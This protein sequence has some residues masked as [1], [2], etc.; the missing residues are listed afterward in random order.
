MILNLIRAEFLKY[1]RFYLIKILFVL[2]LV[3]AGFLF[4]S[5][6]PN[7]KDQGILIMIYMLNGYLLVT[8]YLSDYLLKYD[9]DK[10][11]I[12]LSKNIR[13]KYIIRKII[14][15]TYFAFIG[16]I[17]LYLFMT[18]ALNKIDPTLFN[19]SSILQLLLINFLLLIPFIIFISVI[20][21]FTNIFLSTT[22][23]LILLFF[24]PFINFMLENYINSKWDKANNIILKIYN[25]S[26][27]ANTYGPTNLWTSQFVD[28]QNIKSND[29]FNSKTKEIINKDCTNQLNEKI[30][31]LIKEWKKLE[32]EWAMKLYPEFIESNKKELKETKK[33]WDKIINKCIDSKTSELVYLYNWFD[34]KKYFISNKN[35]TFFY[36]WLIYNL[37]FL[38]LWAYLM[39]R[40]EKN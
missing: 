32:I 12:L 22:I 36:L 11:P 1:K 9:S 5:V 14:V 21:S 18:I 4:Y 13:Y 3:L 31:E 6:I 20:S 16:L 34:V 26:T 38:S 10:W 35:N 7:Y 17:I 27:I 33:D 28:F 19:I 15:I 2:S 30:K 23:S 8:S 25:Y 29:Y 37:L 24:I 39:N 40:K